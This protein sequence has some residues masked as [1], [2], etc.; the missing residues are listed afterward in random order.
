MDESAFID[1]RERGRERFRVQFSPGNRLP[2]PFGWGLQQE[3]WGCFQLL[4]PMAFMCVPGNIVHVFL[5]YLK[6]IPNNYSL[7]VLRK[8]KRFTRT[9][10]HDYAS[11][12]FAPRK[13]HPRW[14]IFTVQQHTVSMRKQTRANVMRKTILCMRIFPSHVCAT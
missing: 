9:N 3:E 10:K 4:L 8:V 12:F 6:F 14:S 7:Q 2:K 13:I 11:V 5:C 1:A